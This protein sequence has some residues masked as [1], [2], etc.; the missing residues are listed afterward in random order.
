MRAICQRCQESVHQWNVREAT[1]TVGAIQYWKMQ[2]CDGCTKEI[3]EA[4]VPLLAIRRKRPARP[5][6]GQESPA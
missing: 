6:D 1:V 5:L 3:E 2:L 4:L